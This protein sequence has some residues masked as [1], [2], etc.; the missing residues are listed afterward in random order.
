MDL[1]TWWDVVER[2]RTAVGERAGDRNLHD[3][4]LPS[5]LT[6]VLATL[7]AEELVDWAVT[8]HAVRESA[9]RWPLWN[10]CMMFE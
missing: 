6:A 3:D 9:Y 7:S 5:A 2:A 10:N 8:H 1:D 4:P